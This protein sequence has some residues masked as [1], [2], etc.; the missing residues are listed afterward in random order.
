MESGLYKKYIGS[1]CK[2]NID[3][4]LIVDSAKKA[5]TNMG[6][7]LTQ[8]TKNMLHDKAIKMDPAN[9]SGKFFSKKHKVFVDGEDG[10]LSNYPTNAKDYKKV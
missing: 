3:P 6:K 10:V 4:K 8:E 1:P 2:K 9:K 7:N 5:T